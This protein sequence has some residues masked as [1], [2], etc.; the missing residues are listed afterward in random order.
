[1]LAILKRRLVPPNNAQDLSGIPPILAKLC[2]ASLI[3]L[4]LG[5]EEPFMSKA[6]PAY[7]QMRCNI[8]AVFEHY[9]QRASTS[10]ALRVSQ[11]TRTV[12]ASSVRCPRPGG[13][14]G[15]AALRMSVQ[16]G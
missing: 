16:I 13:G 15:N 12:T 10:A 14:F 8:D 9:A 5:L 1:V 4:C 6:H 11:G 7:I 2:H 3:M